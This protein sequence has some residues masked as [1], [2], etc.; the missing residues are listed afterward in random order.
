[1]TTTIKIEL[2]AD[3]LSFIERYAKQINRRRDEI[4]ADAIKLL[5]TEWE[6]EQGYIE[7]KKE[8]FDFAEMAIPLFSEVRDETAQTR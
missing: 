1:M 3:L 6:L 8:T 2:Q 5:R 7:D 4:I